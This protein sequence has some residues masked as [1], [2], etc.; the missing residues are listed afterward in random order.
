[1]GVWDDM[2]A[3][4]LLNMPMAVTERAQTST[5]P[6]IARA[7]GPAPHDQSPPWSPDSPLFW[8]GVVAALTFGLVAVS[9]SIRVGPARVSGSL[10]KK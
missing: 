2:T 1:M 4:K 6:G 9:T 7:A 3:A 8:F 5:T 10:G